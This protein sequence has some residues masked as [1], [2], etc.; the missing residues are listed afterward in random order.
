MSLWVD[1]YGFDDDDRMGD[2]EMSSHA[3]ELVK[4]DTIPMRRWQFGDETFIQ[5]TSS[6][7]LHV[8]VSLA[9]KYI[10]KQFDAR[11]TLA[12][13]EDYEWKHAFVMV[14]VDGR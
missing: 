2:M 3:Q 14:F 8:A 4:K 1:L 10:H 9:Q 7:F 12:S 11:A 6:Q 13:A 5:F